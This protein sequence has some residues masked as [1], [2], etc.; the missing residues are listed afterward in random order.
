M[1]GGSGDPSVQQNKQIQFMEQIAF[2][3]L[4]TRTTGRVV[5]I[6]DRKSSKMGLYS[7][8][9]QFGVETDTTKL[10]KTFANRGFFGI[11]LTE[12][13]A[14]GVLKIGDAVDVQIVSYRQSDFNG[15]QNT[16]AQVAFI[17]VAEPNVRSQAAQNLEATPESAQGV[18][19][20]NQ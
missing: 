14:N 18:R 1:C 9:L 7:T 12:K 4:G 6:N 20:T 19:Q 5:K 3:P 11:M 2:L 13:S 17:D 8:I 16:A 10:G 15:Q